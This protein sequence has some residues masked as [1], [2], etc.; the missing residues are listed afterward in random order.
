[1][2]FKNYILNIDFLFSLLIIL[3]L[4]GLVGL[5]CY[6]TNLNFKLATKNNLYVYASLISFVF[7]ILS[8][9]F[10]KTKSLTYEI[11]SL[12]F[13]RFFIIFIFLPILIYLVNRIV[14][15]D[16]YS[17]N[18]INVFN[19]DDLLKILT[20]RIFD[21]SIYSNDLCSNDIYIIPVSQYALFCAVQLD[22]F[23][24]NYYKSKA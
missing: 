22:R 7:L 9:I 20:F 12:T 21:N 23:L 5:L 2:K 16:V 4:S 13:T 3:V 18:L 24:L 17:T 15:L 6:V 8:V 19:Q 10:T 1:M 14:C 11:G